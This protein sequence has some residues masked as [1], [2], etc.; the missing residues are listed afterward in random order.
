MCP[1]VLF[2]KQGLDEREH[3]SRQP[4]FFSDDCN[5][6]NTLSTDCDRQCAFTVETTLAGCMYIEY[7]RT[8][9]TTVHNI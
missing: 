6:F 7:E 1:Q 3:L 8:K 9:C 4:P 2:D 5:T